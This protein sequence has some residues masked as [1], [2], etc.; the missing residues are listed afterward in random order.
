MF[1]T[2]DIQY[3][4][5]YVFPFYAS[6]NT[7]TSTMLPNTRHSAICKKGLVSFQIKNTRPDIKLCSYDGKYPLN[8]NIHC[9]T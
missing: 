9:N 2:L 4:I 1:L 3:S 5:F 8:M 7:D 6:T